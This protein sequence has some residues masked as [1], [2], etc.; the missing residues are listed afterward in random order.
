MSVFFVKEIG[1]E[2]KALCESKKYLSCS[3]S[4]AASV[5]SFKHPVTEMLKCT[6]LFCK[7][8]ACCFF[9]SSRGGDAGL[10]FL[11]AMLAFRGQKTRSLINCDNKLFNRK[12]SKRSGS[13]DFMLVS[14]SLSLGPPGP[15]PT[16]GGTTP[17]PA[18]LEALFCH[19]IGPHLTLLFL[20]MPIWERRAPRVRGAGWGGKGCSFRRAPGGAQNNSPSHRE[21]LPPGQP[22]SSPSFS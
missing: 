5:M 9:C 16:C 14:K 8:K 13:A 20:P 21:G 11:D 22:R 15:S 12:R 17:P 3:Q 18:C 19:E 4:H 2:V 10:C 6:E 1:R 7:E